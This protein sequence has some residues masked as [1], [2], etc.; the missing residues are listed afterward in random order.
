MNIKDI[1]FHAAERGK[2]RAGLTANEMIEDAS[3][4]VLFRRSEKH[5]S[6]KV[7]GLKGVYCVS[8]YGRIT[9]FLNN[10]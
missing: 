2:E 7:L 3:D 6:I 9:T 5:D 1:T 10:N 8:P 4:A